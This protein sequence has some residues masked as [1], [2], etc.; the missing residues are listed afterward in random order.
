MN[1]ISVDLA[2]SAPDAE[3]PVLKM[4]A[5]ETSASTEPSSA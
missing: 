2:L 3:Q 4:S 5:Q 1:A